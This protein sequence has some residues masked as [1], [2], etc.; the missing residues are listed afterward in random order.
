[1]WASPSTT[2]RRCWRRS[3]PPIPKSRWCQ[4][5]FNYADYDDPGVQSR[6]C[7]EVCRRHNKPVL[8]MEPVKGGH[9]SN[10]PPQAKA[11]LDELHGG[12]PASYAIRFAARLRGHP[13]GAL[14]A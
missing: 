14:P 2:G 10:L 3:S 1:M 11:V 4:I 7:Y 6:L 5:Q 9:R 8:V 12:S 13:D